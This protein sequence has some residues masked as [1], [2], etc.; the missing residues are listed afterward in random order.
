M[1]SN[2]WAINITST[3]TEGG[4]LYSSFTDK[5]ST[6][7][8]GASNTLEFDGDFNI[9]ATGDKTGTKNI[10]TSGTA[11]SIKALNTKLTV[12]NGCNDFVLCGGSRMN[13]TSGNIAQSGTSYITDNAFV[14]FLGEET[15]ADINIFNGTLSFKDNENAS[16]TTEDIYLWKNGYFDPRTSVGAWDN[17]ASPSIYCRG[18]GKFVVDTGRTITVL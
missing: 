9:V 6:T 15:S 10:T 8:I 13:A 3:P 12:T 2:L 16:I 4:R 18:G 17:T 7:V 11:T 14:K 1:T 5:Y